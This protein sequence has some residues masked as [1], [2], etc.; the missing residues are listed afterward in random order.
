MNPRRTTSPSP[1]PTQALATFR[2][3][4]RTLS[5]PVSRESTATNLQLQLSPSKAK[6]STTLT[7][8]NS[9]RRHH[10]LKAL[11]LDE[12]S[13]SDHHENFYEFKVK[14]KAPP[15]KITMDPAARKA[16]LQKQADKQRAIIEASL[17]FACKRARRPVV[18]S[19]AVRSAE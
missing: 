3:R 19:S 18:R 5:R 10:L 9:H 4:G 6:Q 11:T 13:T 1:T 16:Y 17:A 2:D 8:R 14:K 7:L 12:G 15:K